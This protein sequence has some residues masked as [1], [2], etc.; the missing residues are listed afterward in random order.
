MLNLTG[1]KSSSSSARKTAQ[2]FKLNSKLKQRL[3]A[4]QTKR[5]MHTIRLLKRWIDCGTQSVGRGAECWALGP[6]R[7][8]MWS[9]LWW[10]GPNDPLCYADDILLFGIKGWVNGWPQWQQPHSVQCS[11]RLPLLVQVWF[12]RLSKGWQSRV[13]AVLIVQQ[14][15]CPRRMQ[16]HL[17]VWRV[18]E[19]R[20]DEQCWN[21]S[22]FIQSFI[23]LLSGS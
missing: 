15:M 9:H 19:G 8:N 6:S 14:K 1:N 11:K 23:T 21:I 4:A 17:P 18:P 20:D 13:A 2:I 5:T 7:T 10:M 12:R 22:V 16:K 3:L